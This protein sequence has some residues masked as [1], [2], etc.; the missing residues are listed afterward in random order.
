MIKLFSHA[1]LMFWL[2]VKLANLAGFRAAQFWS[3]L[4]SNGDYQIHLFLY[5]KQLV[6]VIYVSKIS[7]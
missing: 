2:V 7:L 1:K 6:L 3:M 4:Q 5:I